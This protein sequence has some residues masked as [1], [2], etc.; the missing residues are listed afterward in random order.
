[1]NRELKILL[2]DDVD[3]ILDVERDFLKRTPAAVLMA[4]DGREALEL[5]HR[6]RPDLIY[7]DVD[8]PVMDGLTCCREIKK[9]PYLRTIP[10]IVV[11]AGHH[12]ENERLSAE[13]GADGHL[14]KPL[15][16]IPFLEIGHNFLFP[17][18]RREKRYP[19]QAPVNF[20]LNGEALHGMVY[21]INSGGIY[22]QYRQPVEPEMKIQLSFHLPTN[23]A[24]TIEA[25]GRVAWLNQGFPRKYLSMPQG[26]GVQFQQISNE[27]TEVVR[28]YL[29]QQVSAANTSQ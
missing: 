25:K 26:F 13:A 15:E 12:P 22:I 11:F 16:R 27:A 24:V 4:R 14:S 2:A 29:A 17:V 5:V 19:C 1:M 9:D 21:D 7:L 8:M 23:A 6:E 18:D 3:F 28:A 10:L 20:S